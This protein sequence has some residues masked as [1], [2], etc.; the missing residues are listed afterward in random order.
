[1]ESYKVNWYM[2]TIDVI[3]GVESSNTEELRNRVDSEFNTWLARYEWPLTV[4]CMTF[5]LIMHNQNVFCNNVYARSL[6][7]TDLPQIIALCT[8]PL[9]LSYG[10]SPINGTHTPHYPSKHEPIR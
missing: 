7:S 8:H 1:M 4:E 10:N 6:C 9:Q 5:E 2:M 3:K